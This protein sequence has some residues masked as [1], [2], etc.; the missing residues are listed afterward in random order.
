MCG[1]ITHDKSSLFTHMQ[2]GFCQI[3]LAL[4]IAK[5]FTDG[6]ADQELFDRIKNDTYMKGAIQ[7][8][9]DLFE[10]ILRALVKGEHECK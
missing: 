5:D 6:Q 10:D 9:Y 2:W 7:E 1:L 4:D 3:A 8:C